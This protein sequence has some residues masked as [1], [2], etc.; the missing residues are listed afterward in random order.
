MHFQNFHCYDIKVSYR[1][2]KLRKVGGKLDTFMLRRW[3]ILCKY[4]CFCF[5]FLG[6]RGCFC[7]YPLP[8]NPPP[9]PSP[10][11]HTHAEMVIYSWW[12][13]VNIIILF[14]FCRIAMIHNISNLHFIQY[15]SLI[16]WN[17]YLYFEIS[18]VKM[19]YI[20]FVVIPTSICIRTISTPSVDEMSREFTFCT[21]TDSDW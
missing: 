15:I 2:W 12:K 5:F 19:I 6:G 11:Q 13:Q 14:F 8:F 16:S 3:L 18:R 7:I 10:F 1:L 21:H 20:L 17:I 4:F 9:P